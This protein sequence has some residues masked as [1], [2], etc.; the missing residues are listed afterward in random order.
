MDKAILATRRIAKQAL[1]A[2]IDHHGLADIARKTPAER[3]DCWVVVGDSIRHCPDGP[4]AG[5]VATIELDIPTAYVTLHQPSRLIRH[6]SVDEYY[7]RTDNDPLPA[8]MKVDLREWLLDN[9]DALMMPP[10]PVKYQRR[11]AIPSMKSGW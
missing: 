2:V 10:R 3:S 9:I 4:D 8:L 5:R 1:Y 7:A 6:G 11:A